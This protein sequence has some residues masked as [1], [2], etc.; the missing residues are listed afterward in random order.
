MSRSMFRQTWRYENGK[1]TLIRHADNA[2][3]KRQQAAMD[4][5]LEEH[6]RKARQEGRHDDEIISVTT[7]DAARHAT[8]VNHLRDANGTS[9][10]ISPRE[11]EEALASPAMRRII[12]HA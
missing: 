5:Q 4:Y 7:L 11:Y 6:N 2:S 12:D 9:H 8:L 3:E 10:R 1:S